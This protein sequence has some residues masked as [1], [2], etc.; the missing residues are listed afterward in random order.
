MTVSL[1]RT[2]KNRTKSEEIFLKKQV[3]RASSTQIGRAS[4][5]QVDLL[6]SSELT[7]RNS[8]NN[9]LELHFNFQFYF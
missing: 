4:S 3:G 1:N 9:L 8:V 2:Y 5:T 7:N 6:L